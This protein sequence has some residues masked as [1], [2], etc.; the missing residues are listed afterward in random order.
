MEE[1]P[2][3]WNRD[4]I[5]QNFAHDDAEAI[6]NI[7]LSKYNQED[8]LIWRASKTCEFSVKSAHH[9]EKEIV[10]RSKGEC[11]KG[12]KKQN[13]WKLM[14][15]L[16]LPN[17]AKM[18][19]WR[20]CKNILHTKDN[21]K[22]RKVV[23]DDTCIICCREVESVHHILWDCPSSQDVWCSVGGRL[24]KRGTGGESF[25]ELVE[26]LMEFLCKEELELFVWTTKMIWKRRNGVI[27]G[28]AFLHPR[29][30][31][32]RTKEFL[33]QFRKAN[34]KNQGKVQ[35][36]QAPVQRWEAPP[37]GIYKVNWDIAINHSEKRMGV[38]AAIR[39][40]EGS[41]IAA[42]CKPIMAIHEPAAAEATTAL[43]AVEF[44]K[45]VGIQD[46]L[47][48]GD[49]MLV[50]TAINDSRPN[51]L[52][53]GQIIDDVKMVLNSLRKWSSRHIKREANSAAH[54]LAKYTTRINESQVWLEDAPTCIFEVVNLEQL[55]LSL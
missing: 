40:N 35:C 12:T 27:H 7:P 41:V 47:L 14:W 48:E 19:L 6:C 15:G 43:S 54:G 23:A 2:V 49:S 52:R 16:K 13:I 11:S 5:F 44:C 39:D 28:E 36:N 18:F 37:P 4:F 32:Q 26:N 25:M 3:Q 24:Q 51:W 45:E 20:A 34:E 38:G 30:V 10:E 42:L 53:Y 33:Q 46:I 9:L 50:V 31:T 1:H 55:A 21:L 8:K 22:K 17:S 29:V